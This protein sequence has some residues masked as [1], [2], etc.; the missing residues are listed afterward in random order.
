MGR[1]EA[2]GEETA[3][4]IR[5]GGAECLFVRSDV[6]S[7]AEVQ[8]LV[9]KTISWVQLALRERDLWQTRLCL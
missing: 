5:S 9:E 1:R 6:S 3:A 4:L 2:E 8:A 7:E